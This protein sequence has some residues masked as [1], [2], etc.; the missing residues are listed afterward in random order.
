MSC[1]SF[2]RLC[3][4]FTSPKDCWC[5]K[6]SDVWGVAFICQLSSPAFNAMPRR[7][8]VD[9]AA[10]SSK[11]LEF[12]EVALV[13]YVR[14]RSRDSHSDTWT[15][16]PLFAREHSSYSFKMS[17]CCP[18]STEERKTGFLYEMKCSCQGQ[19]SIC[20]CRPIL[21]VA[22]EACPSIFVPG[23]GARCSCV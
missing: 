3:S 1:L 2:L 21:A 13:S 10:F 6:G 12:F 15:S 8:N 7:L 14:R 16:R 4:S 11:S 20:S 18:R 19:D 23:R 9:F 22:T 17:E 5:C